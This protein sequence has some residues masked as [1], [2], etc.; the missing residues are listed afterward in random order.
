MVE[1]IPGYSVPLRGLKEAMHAFH[2]DNIVHADC[3]SC[4]T[5]LY[6]IDSASMVLCPTCRSISPVPNKGKNTATESLSIGLTVEHIVEE[7]QKLDLE[8]P[9]RIYQRCPF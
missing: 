7:Y 4:D 1:V 3:S 5:F 6:C 2:Q 9:S 8:E